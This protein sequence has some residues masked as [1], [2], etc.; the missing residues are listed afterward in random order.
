MKPSIK[1]I[2]NGPLQVSGITSIERNGQTQ[3][4]EG[5]VFLCRCGQ[6][7]NK[8]Y[9]DGSHAKVGFDDARPDNPDDRRLTFKK[10]R[11][12]VYE[13][14]A[15]CCHAGH[16]PKGQPDQWDLDDVDGIINIVKSCPSGALSYA[17]DDTEHRDTERGAKLIVDDLSPVKAE[18]G[19]ELQAVSWG[20]GASREHYA[21][22]TCG[23][24]GMKPFCDGS[25][26]QA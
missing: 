26:D 6:S 24:S 8:P 10:D 16:C 18:G 25:H 15:I 9:C 3:T 5:P 17:L 12:T 21:L 4:V 14:V 19:I 22:C 13:N 11:L 1:P 2:K 7:A 20:E 23:R